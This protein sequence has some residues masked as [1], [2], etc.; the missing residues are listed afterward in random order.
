[1]ARPLVLSN[2]TLHVGLN[3]FG[4]VHDFYYPHVGL[5]NHSS[6][7][8]TRHHLGVWIDG[9]LSWLDNNDEWSFYFRYPYQALIG[10]T[11]A[12]NDRLG[13]ILE[14]DDFVDA[15][16]NAF[17]RNIH[18][19]NT[20]S[21]AR[22]IRVFI[23]QAFVI[24]D[25]RSNTDTAQYLPD[26]DAILHYRGRR[27]FIVG[28]T[29]NDGTPFDQHSIGV[30]GIEGR[31]GTWRDAEDGVLS[32]SNVEHGRVDSTIRFAFHVDGLSSERLHYWIAAGTSMRQA[33]SVDRTIRDDGV[34]KRLHETA[35]YWKQWTGP[36]AAVAEKIDEAYREQFMHSVMIIKAHADKHGAVIASTD[37]S[38]LK[39]SRDDYEYCWPRDGAMVLWPF[40]RMGYLDEAM[41]F[42]EF[43]RRGLH[44]S[45]YLMQKYRADGGLG[46]SW[47]SY[48]HEDGIVGPPIQE[49]ETAIVLFVLA[50]SY[51]TTGKRELLDEFYE[52]LV[53]PMANFLAEYIDDKTHLP[54]PSYDLW[55]EVY[56]TTTYTTA[57]TQAAL[58]AAADLAEVVN[59]AGNAV[60]WR[61]VADDMLE[62]ARKHL[63]DHERGA[64][65]KGIRTSS[66]GIITPDATL[67]SASLYGVFMFG[68][69]PS[70]GPEFAAARQAFLD[71][72]GAQ[73]EG[74]P[75]YENDYY[76]RPEG[77]SQDNY[78]IITTLWQ[79]QI[80]L[81]LGH[82]GRA[83]EL[84]RWVHDKATTTGMLAEQIDPVSGAAISPSPLVWSQAEYLS[85]LLDTIN[86][87]EHS[88][89]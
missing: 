11:V 71:R 82:H 72:F 89:S 52:S 35:R 55:E 28:G 66:D 12:R 26:S 29:H 47:H 45:G 22:E 67:D 9:E 81:E 34:N 74:Y 14:M 69:F 17:M 43:C 46:A 23:H 48:V 77:A 25:S 44:P 65:Y 88:S 79:A 83:D 87:S 76:H 16:I 2:G 70:S 19:I 32:N 40:I 31:E 80:A 61:T 24:G 42:F 36:A 3:N 51:H 4:L 84:L 30:F 15:D 58:A 27:A 10:H 1:M 60:R 62:S 18:V 75:R 86:D 54:R 6:G 38:M 57:V 20:R 50:Q 53:R 41:A 7:S 59:D 78:W 63:Y 64:F 13:V 56:M 37:S 39:Y 8:Q 21:E 73:A 49:D 5:E 85:T 33:L 68:L